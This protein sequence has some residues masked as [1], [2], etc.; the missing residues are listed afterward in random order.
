MLKVSILRHTKIVAE[1][2][3]STSRLQL[4]P[5]LRVMC[6]ARSS[7][8]SIGNEA[9]HRP[10]VLGFKSSRHFYVSGAFHL[11]S[12]LITFWNLLTKLNYRVY[13][14]GRGTERCPIS[15]YSLVMQYRDDVS[16]VDII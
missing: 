2:V 16:F 4:S 1:D 12:S 14:S 3:I 8:W 7:P 9:G 10:V 5:L 11:S 13:K 15:R 6:P